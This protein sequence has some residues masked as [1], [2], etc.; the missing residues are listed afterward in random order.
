MKL[1]GERR[2]EGDSVR[3][4]GVGEPRPELPQ[5]AREHCDLAEW[6]PVEPQARDLARH[7]VR[8]LR[9]VPEGGAG[10]LGG[11]LLRGGE[12]LAAVRIDVAAYH[13]RREI[14]DS[15]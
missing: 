5:R 11:T 9:G 3:A 7:P 1:R 8:L 15:G 12:R 14:D 10:Q 2:M 13:A 6:S 4:Q